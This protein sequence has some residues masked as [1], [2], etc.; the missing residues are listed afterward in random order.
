MVP[1]DAAMN[2]ARE[3]YNNGKN[4]PASEPTRTPT[5]NRTL[6]FRGR[7]DVEISFNLD[8]EPRPAPSRSRPTM[9]ALGSSS[10]T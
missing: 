4:A 6:V 7:G 9:P 1:T 10:A 5:R 8:P 3:L 2:V